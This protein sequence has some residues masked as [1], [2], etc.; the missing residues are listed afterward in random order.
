MNEAEYLANPL[1]EIIVLKHVCVP[2]MENISLLQIIN[3]F[4]SYQCINIY[5]NTNSV[6]KNLENTS[7]ITIFLKDEFHN[8]Q[9]RHRVI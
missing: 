2:V 7:V 6:P 4:S 1:F 9:S 3:K 5:K 8:G